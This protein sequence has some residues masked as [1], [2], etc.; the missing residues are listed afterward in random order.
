MFEGLDVQAGLRWNQTHAAKPLHNVA[1]TDRLSSYWPKNATW[2]LLDNTQFLYGR[3]A[4]QRA[5]AL[6]LTRG[7]QGIGTNFLATT[8]GAA[9]R[10]DVVAFQR[11]MN[12]WMH[13]F[14]GVYARTEPL[15]TIGVF[16]RAARGGAAQ[17]AHRGRIRPA[18]R[19]YHGSHE[20]KVTEALFLC[21]AAGW[22]ARIITYP[23]DPARPA[24]ALDEGA[25]CSSA[26][27]RMKRASPG[28]RE[29]KPLLEKF[30]AR[31]GRI[32]VDDESDCAV[33]HTETG[34][35]VAAY[36]PQSDVDATPLLFA[37][38]RENIAKLR[39]AHAGR[40]AAARR[41]RGAETLGHSRRSAATRN[42]SPRS[43]RLRRRRRGQRAVC[44]PPTSARRARKSW[45]TKANASL[46][47]KPQNGTLT[48]HTDRPIYDVRLAR[49]L[50][51]EEA[52]SV[53]LTTDAFA[54]YALPPAEPTVPV[55]T[56][57]KG[58]SGFF[59]AYATIANPQPIRGIPVKVLIYRDNEY[60]EL[61]GAS[62][63]PIRL[64]LTER[65]RPGKYEVAV[66]ELLSGLEGKSHRRDRRAETRNRLAFA[67][68]ARD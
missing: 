15:A 51:P 56:V 52:A 36:E 42:T 26:C 1:L 60:A 58:T 29:L 68:R 41:L 50:T 22:P 8:R 23:G 21:H 11:E 53:D 14:G 13:R 48:W 43:T 61:Y 19:C 25:S 35:H 27:A 18:R 40:R 59:E 5:C 37:R 63:W 62:G 12:A 31:G 44:A 39:A 10:P 57:A 47:V 17:R 24:A 54:F 6:A 2:S 20:G 7:V 66:T 32:L 49:K 9:A 64:P 4:Y 30:L 3:E 28:A 33:A 38:N 46:Y 65:D 16:Y 34:L 67:R 55:V 45:K